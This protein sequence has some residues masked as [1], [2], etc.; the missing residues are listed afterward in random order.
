MAV[1][2][3][4]LHRGWCCGSRVFVAGSSIFGET[5][6]VAAAMSRLRA[7]ILNANTLYSL[8]SP[9]LF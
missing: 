9:L 6:G 2:M 4:Q 7:N 3:K 1:S 5:A 8:N